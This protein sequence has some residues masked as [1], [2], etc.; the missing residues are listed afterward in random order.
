MRALQRSSAALPT[1]MPITTKARP[2]EPAGNWGTAAKE[3]RIPAPLRYPAILLLAA[4]WCAA[5]AAGPENWVE[6][7]SPNFITVTNANEKQ[8]RR[9]AYQFEMIRAVF[10]EFFNLQGSAQ[11]QPVIIIA[12]IDE[13]TLKTL[14]PEYW[15]GRRRA[16]AGLRL[17]E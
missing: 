9:V 8:A 4:P 6:L 15:A 11:D 12:A 17:E 3:R 16:S 1:E 2:H 10:R 7:R 5:F 14:L 13:N